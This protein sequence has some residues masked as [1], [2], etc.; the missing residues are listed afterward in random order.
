MHFR[1]D[2]GRIEVRR[3]AIAKSSV[4]IERGRVEAEK[5]S[6]ELS[7]HVMSLSLLEVSAF[8]F[9][10][11]PGYLSIPYVRVARRIR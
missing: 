9:S 7:Q 6:D 1:Q 2:E 5:L 4:W 8:V 10:T 3:E 11:T